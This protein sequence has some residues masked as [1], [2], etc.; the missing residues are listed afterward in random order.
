M[1]KVI[2]KQS[3]RDPTEEFRRELNSTIEDIQHLTLSDWEKIKLSP[4]ISHEP[5]TYTYTD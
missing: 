3:V 4:M 5:A 2:R 1:Q